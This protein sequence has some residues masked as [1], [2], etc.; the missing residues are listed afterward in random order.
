MKTHAF[1]VRSLEPYL[2]DGGVFVRF[3]YDDQGQQTAVE[4][5]E[6]DLKNDIEAKGGIPS[7]LGLSGGSVWLVKGRPWKE[8]CRSSNSFSFRLTL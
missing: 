5:I 4:D 6:R 1:K 3:G 2:K 8:V 7:W